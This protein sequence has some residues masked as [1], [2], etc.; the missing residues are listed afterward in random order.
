MLSSIDTCTRHSAVSVLDTRQYQ[1][2]VVPVL[3]T[4]YTTNTQQSIL[5]TI[6]STRLQY[7]LCDNITRYLNNRY[8]VLSVRDTASTQ[9]SVQ[10]PDNRYCQ[11]PVR[12][13]F[14]TSVH[15]TTS[16]LL[17]FLHSSC[18]FRVTSAMSFVLMWIICVLEWW[19][20]YSP[21]ARVDH[22]DLFIW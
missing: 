20:L 21:Q 19:W 1:Y 3:D 14:G 16:T 10:M 9:Y 15:I 17:I 22:I 2:S 11:Y 8:S 6:S 5:G 12:P 13:V 4:I 7:S 18:R